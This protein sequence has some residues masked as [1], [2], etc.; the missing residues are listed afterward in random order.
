MSIINLIPFFQHSNES[1]GNANEL[2]ST[3]VLA[4]KVHNA[5]IISFLIY[6]GLKEKHQNG[7]NF[8]EDRVSF[9]MQPIWSCVKFACVC[10]S[11]PTEITNDR[12]STL[13]SIF[14]NKTLFFVQL[15]HGFSDYNDMWFKWFLNCNKAKSDC[16]FSKKANSGSIDWK[17]FILFNNLCF[18]LIFR[19]FKFKLSIVHRGNCSFICLYIKTLSV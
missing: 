15:N 6:P 2:P 8:L 7:L 19:I 4:T 1:F 10:R 5:V 12:R 18:Q 17:K 11:S 3:Y 16:E 9:S 13:W 14:Y